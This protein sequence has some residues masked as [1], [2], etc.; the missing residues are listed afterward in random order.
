[1]DLLT[2]DTQ[3]LEIS[4]TGTEHMEEAV[5]I[6]GS[7]ITK[8]AGNDNNLSLLIMKDPSETAKSGHFDRD[9]VPIFTKRGKTIL[10][11]TSF[12]KIVESFK[13]DMY[14][15]LADGDTSKDSAS[16]RIYKAVD[17]SDTFFKACLEIHKKS[18]KLK[19][20]SIIAAIEGG[21]NEKARETS[22][23]YLKEHNQD[24]SGYLIDGLHSNGAD[25]VNIEEQPVLDIV[26]Y[27][28]S[29]LPAEK[30]R[31]AFGPYNPKMI[32]EL[33]KIG[34]DVFDSS[35]AFIKST[36]NEAI[37]FCF[38][39][40]N[41]A[42]LDNRLEIDLADP[43]HKDVFEPFV[44]NCCCLA[45]RK[46]TRAY[47]HHLVNTREMLGPILLMIHNLH[48]YIEFFKVI[49]QHVKNDSLGKILQHVSKQKQ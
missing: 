45:C 17:K 46:H 36:Q 3:I 32:L 43:I 42:N 6:S 23:N 24:I 14:H 19:N 18:D 40:K 28:N 1:M 39:I 47:V 13:P 31:F 4:L 12:M 15:P 37:T 29:L 21:Y 10:T 22:Y 16:K 41:E 7:S 35:Y 11:P 20:T 48:H 49:R 8:F 26:S 2:K 38:D 30:P 33:V 9:A 44:K 5:G 34:V 25:V 27:T